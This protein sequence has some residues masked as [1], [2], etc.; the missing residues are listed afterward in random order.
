LVT[1]IKAGIAKGQ[2]TGLIPIDIGNL[3]NLHGL[4]LSDNQLSGEI[5]D[6]IC[7]LVE[8]DCNL[9]I[10]NNQLCPPYPYC[11]E[12]NQGYQDLSEC[13]DC[14][15]FGDGYEE[16]W[17]DC[18]SIEETT[19]LDL[20]G[21][22]DSV[23]E[24]T[25]SIPSEIG[26]FINLTYL[27]LSFNQLIG[28]IPESIDNLNNLVF[29]SL[30][31]NQLNGGIPLEIGNLIN[32]K[33]LYLYNNQL[34]G[35]IP[36]SVGNLYNLDFLSLH[37]NQLTGEIP[38]SLCNNYQNIDYIVLDIN[39]LCPPYPECLTE[40]NIGYQ[41]TSECVDCPDSIEGDIDSDGE[42]TILDIVL[43]LNCILSNNCDECYDWNFDGNV[44]VLD[45]ILMINIILTP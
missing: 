37:S 7:N 25:G 10:Y 28:E 14:S 3:E 44:D 38:Q 35:A 40:E 39:H 5:S 21:S 24:L 30:H 33:W 11:I 8:N 29:L 13:G 4:K 34:T 20:S 19:I 18:Y 31:S 27:D 41:D 17:G 32:L 2:F 45:I 6:N 42:V 16:L 43:I 36:E 22:W 23:G 15:S 1:E 9:Y 12:G 26:N